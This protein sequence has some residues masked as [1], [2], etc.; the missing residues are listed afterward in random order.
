[1]QTRYLLDTCTLVAMLKDEYGIRNKI[2]EVG[3]E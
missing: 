3:A 2:R 1:M